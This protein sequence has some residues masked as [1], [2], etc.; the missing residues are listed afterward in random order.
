MGCF[1]RLF[2]RIFLFTIIYSFFYS[3][4]TQASCPA[5]YV[6]AQ[7]RKNLESSMEVE[8]R[9]VQKGSSSLTPEARAILDL[10]RPVGGDWQTL[11][12]KEIPTTKT[13]IHAALMPYQNK[14]WDQI[15]FEMRHKFLVALTLERQ[16]NFL[17]SRDLKDFELDPTKTPQNL[18]RALQVE[19]GSQEDIPSVGLLEFHLR[20]GLKPSVLAEKVFKYLGESGVSKDKAHVHV[21]G[22]MPTEYIQKEGLPALAQMV[23]HFRRTHLT[24][25]AISIM[26]GNIAIRELSSAN[27]IEMGLLLD[28]S[29]VRFANDLWLATTESQRI[30]PDNYKAPHVGYHFPGKY[31]DPSLMGYQ[32]RTVV[33]DRMHLIGP[34]M[35]QSQQALNTL[36]TGISLETFKQWLATQNPNISAGGIGQKLSPFTSEV[37][38][39]IAP[40]RIKRNQG[41]RLLFYEWEKDILFFGAPEARKLEISKVRLAAIEKLKSGSQSDQ[42]ILR[43]FLRNSGVYQN[44]LG[45]YGVF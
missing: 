9:V 16:P 33:K 27:G 20:G 45:G 17:F 3:H 24:L 30:D 44:L 43:E 6:L 38:S 32:F 40:D 29:L 25:S 28:S 37:P 35:D 36:N 34:I 7:Y 26:E 23:E 18:S 8:P 5:E 41:L 11:L 14:S 10:I 2:F 39:F 22:P 12:L 15:P 13:E 1:A 31:D 19:Y 4:K 42:M 21:P